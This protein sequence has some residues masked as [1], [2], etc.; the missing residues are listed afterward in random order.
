MHN[1]FKVL[2]NYIHI[3]EPAQLWR[4]VENHLFEEY[5]TLP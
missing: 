4:P 5:A 2:D 3:I 1:H